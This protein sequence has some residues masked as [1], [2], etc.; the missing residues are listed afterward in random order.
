MES[1]K[2]SRK[3]AKKTK[4]NEEQGKGGKFIKKVDIME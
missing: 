3:K 2:G 1:E 4:E